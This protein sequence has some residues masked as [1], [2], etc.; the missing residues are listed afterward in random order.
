VYAVT[1]AGAAAVGWQVGRGR[2]REPSLAFLTHQLGVAEVFVRLHEA[3]H[4]GAFLDLTVQTEP[5]CWRPLDD[6][7]GSILKPDLYVL[8]GQ[9]DHER[10]AFVEIDNGTEHAAAL[11]RKAALY[12]AHYASGREQEAEGVFPE[13]LWLAPDAARVAQLE[14]AFARSSYS[15]LHQLFSNTDDLIRHLSTGEPPP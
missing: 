4:S 1:P 11:G 3:W 15:Q 6:G 13:V 14:A 12:A 2:L 7:T 10:L 5:D 8:T 9:A